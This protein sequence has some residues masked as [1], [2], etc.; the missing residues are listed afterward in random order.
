MQIP[1]T[2]GDL[3]SL[4]GVYALMNLERWSRKTESDPGAGTDDNLLAEAY[5]FLRALRAIST[6]PEGD[7]I[8]AIT[9]GLDLEDV[10]W[11]SKR[12]GTAELHRA[13]ETVASVRQALKKSQPVIVYFANSSG[14]SHYSVATKADVSSGRIELFDSWGFESFENG[15]LKRKAGRPDISG[16]KLKA[17]LTG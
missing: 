12:V 9:E 6:H 7:L 17:V 10:I 15:T 4:C 11:L 16:V 1:V 3:D 8:N 14:F 5:F 2:Q 13:G